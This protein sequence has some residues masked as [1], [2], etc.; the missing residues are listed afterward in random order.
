MSSNT[1]VQ[2]KVVKRATRDYSTGKIYKMFVPGKDN[3]CYIGST[4][5]ILTK[6]LYHHKSASCSDNQKKC[7]SSVLFENNANVVIELVEDFP[8]KTKLE[9]EK[10]E[11]HWIEQFPDA[12]NKNIP[13]RDWRERRAL[14]PEKYKLAK[15]EWTANNKDHIA[16]YDASRREINKEQA[17]A[18]YDNGYKERRN[19]AKKEKAE[20]DICK[21][22][23]NKNSIWTHKNTVHKT[24]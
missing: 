23:M 12:I 4:T 19:E 10:R 7:A 18:R 1:V 13:T 16:E 15:Q 2:P 9:L 8:C 24:E 5:W 21:K 14:D 22:V 20:C 17:K 3:V 11:R 6:R